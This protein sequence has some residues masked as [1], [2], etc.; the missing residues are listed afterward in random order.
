MAKESSRQKASEANTL[1]R[2][3]CQQP[4][5][6]LYPFHGLPPPIYNVPPPSGEFFSPIFP[7]YYPKSGSTTLDPL[8]AVPP[9]LSI[10]PREPAVQPP[11]FHYP[12]HPLVLGYSGHYPTS[13]Y[14]GELFNPHQVRIHME[15]FDVQNCIL[16][17]FG[18]PPPQSLWKSM[19]PGGSENDQQSS[20]EHRDRL[21]FGELRRDWEPRR[22]ETFIRGLCSDATTID[23]YPEGGPHTRNRGFAFVS[24]PDAG[25]AFRARERLRSDV[26]RMGGRPISVDWARAEHIVPAEVMRTV[27]DLYNTNFSCVIFGFISFKLVFR[28]ANQLEGYSLRQ[29]EL[30]PTTATSSVQVIS[31]QTAFINPPLSTIAL[32]PFIGLGPALQPLVSAA[33]PNTNIVIVLGGFRFDGPFAQNCLEAEEAAATLMFNY[34][35]C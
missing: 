13:F 25:A 5:I 29:V 30:P 23:T 16:P 33:E 27:G 32:P 18:P 22:V 9:Y 19:D 1:P 26:P 10:F 3:H 2:D 11:F 34:F 7:Q 6:E 31:P 20:T 28:G 8:I 17:I 12:H 35:R 15:M 21:F 24:F 14:H 4:P